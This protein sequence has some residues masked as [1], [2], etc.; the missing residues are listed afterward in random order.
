MPADLL[1]AKL[2]E[3]ERF[4]RAELAYLESLSEQEGHTTGIRFGIEQGILVYR[5]KLAHLDENRTQLL[6]QHRAPARARREAER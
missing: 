4:Y 2:D 5:A 3:I 1:A 6:Q